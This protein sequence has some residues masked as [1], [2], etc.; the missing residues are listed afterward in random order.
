M[1]P[2]IPTAPVDPFPERGTDPR[3]VALERM[4][5]PILQQRQIDKWKIIAGVCFALVAGG[6]S[7]AVWLHMSF[8]SQTDITRVTHNAEKTTKSVDHLT[9]NVTALTVNMAKL[10]TVVAASGRLQD[11]MR[12]DIREIKEESRVPVSRR[13]AMARSRGSRARVG[14]FDDALEQVQLEMVPVRA[15]GD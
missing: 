13:A 10:T 12:M 4:T 1:P 11:E 6:F 3:L 8:A 15:L 9:R 2:R 5:S 7:A 14:T